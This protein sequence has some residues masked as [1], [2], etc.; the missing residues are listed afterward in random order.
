M[1]GTTSWKGSYEIRVQPDGGCFSI[2]LLRDGRS[3]RVFEELT[4]GEA[5]L[6]V[7]DFLVRDV[8]ANLGHD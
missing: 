5:G 4:V 7:G 1:A 2:E 6:V 3:I 8:A